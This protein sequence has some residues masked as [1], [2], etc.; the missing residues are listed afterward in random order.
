[1]IKTNEFVHS[2]THVALVAISHDYKRRVF[3]GAEAVSSRK[4]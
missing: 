2:G 1:M 4:D 3:R